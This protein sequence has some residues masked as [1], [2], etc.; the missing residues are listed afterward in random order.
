MSTFH[1]I[2][3]QVLSVLQRWLLLRLLS[4]QDEEPAQGRKA[5][6]KQ[7][8]QHTHTLKSQILSNEIVQVPVNCLIGVN[9]ESL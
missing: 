3:K 5:V 6:K 8:Q 4:K 1:P 9:L 7:Q 2:K